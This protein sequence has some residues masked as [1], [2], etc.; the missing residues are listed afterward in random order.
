MS[1]ELGECVITSLDDGN[2][3]IERADPRI[4]ISGHL[5]DSV[6][7]FGDDALAGNW[8]ALNAWLDMSRCAPPPWRATYIGAVLKVVGVNQTAIYRITEYM[9]SIDEYVGE[10]P[11]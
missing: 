7:K 4:A 3:R 1:Q 2:I 9:P 11:D 5:L 10:W 8:V 6:A